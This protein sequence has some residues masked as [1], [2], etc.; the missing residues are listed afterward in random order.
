MLFI[1]VLT[2]NTVKIFASPN[3]YKI[4]KE[5]VP[6]IKQNQIT[7][8]EDDWLSGCSFFYFQNDNLNYCDQNEGI[9]KSKKA[10]F[11]QI[12]SYGVSKFD[13]SNYLKDERQIYNI[14]F[15]FSPFFPNSEYTYIQNF[16]F[17]L[18]LIFPLTFH[19]H[20]RDIPT[21]LYLLEITIW[22]F[23]LDNTLKLFVN[24]SQKQKLI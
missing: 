21:I 14:N 7:R 9:E 1:V 16:D 19:W 11:D 4:E 2:L 5:L 13:V 17:Y 12:K 22:Y 18:S 15:T 23:I 6:I 24:K 3:L 10:L 8:F 20:L